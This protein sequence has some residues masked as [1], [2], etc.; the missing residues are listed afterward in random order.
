MAEDG[1]LAGGEHG[2]H[3]APSLSQRRVAECIDASMNPVKV[4]TGYPPIG[5]PFVDAKGLDL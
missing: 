2:R 4:S 3:P 1:A 5:K